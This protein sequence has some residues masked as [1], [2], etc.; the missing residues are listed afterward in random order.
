MHPSAEVGAPLVF[1]VVFEARTLGTSKNQ[2]CVSCE[3][4]E[5]LENSLLVT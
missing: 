5:T 2:E 4:F 3:E 1:L